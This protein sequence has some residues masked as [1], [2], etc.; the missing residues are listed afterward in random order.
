M[1]PSEAVTVVLVRLVVF[2][3]M[4]PYLPFPAQEAKEEPAGAPEETNP[5]QEDAAE[6]EEE[7]AEDDSE[8]TVSPSE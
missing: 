8:R 7:G 5:A 4:F 2:V 6:E 1:P 3:T